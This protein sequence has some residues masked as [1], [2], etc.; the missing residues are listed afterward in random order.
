[1]LLDFILRMRRAISIAIHAVLIALAHLGA[2]W[3]RFDSDVPEDYWAL[4]RAMLPAV[5]AI[6]LAVF[7]PLRLFEGLWKYTGVW[8]LRNIVL[9]VFGSTLLVFAAASQFAPE[10]GYPRSIYM[11][12]SLLLVCMLGGVRM[13]R[14]I[15]RE[16]TRHASPRAVLIYGAGD[17]GEMIVRDMR[18]NANYDVRPVGFVDDDPHKVGDRIHGVKVLGGRED[19]PRIIEQT[20]PDEVLITMPSAPPAVLRSIVRALEPYKVRITTLPRLADLVRKRAEVGQIRQLR[21][22]DLLAREPVALDR[23]LVRKALSGKRILVTGAGG[24]IGSELCRQIAATG[25]S[26]LV[27]LDRYENALY[28]AHREVGDA[29]PGLPVRPVIAGAGHGGAGQSVRHGAG[30]DPAGRL[31]SRQGYRDHIHGHQARR[32]TPRRAG[33]RRRARRAVARAEDHDHQQPHVTRQPGPPERTPRGPRAGGARRARRGRRHTPVPHRAELYASGSAGLADS[34][35]VGSGL[36][37]LGF[38]PAKV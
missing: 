2:F 9:G 7:Y 15:Y 5:L 25:P 19:L 37:A 27:M 10:P 32:K 1:M 12:D 29:H 18:Q 24:S 4:A 30:P 16:V 23:E 31:H 20:K 14:R 3:L 28:F 38:R 8:D 33:G 36:P 35:V 13:S 17:A 6:R 34:P 11:I 21:V 22:E 26:E